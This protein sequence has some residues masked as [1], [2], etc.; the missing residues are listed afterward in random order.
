V[1]VAIETAIQ[2]GLFKEITKNDKP[3]TAIELA[4]ATGADTV[5]LSTP[6]HLAIDDLC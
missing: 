5:F 3:K 6:A 4:E 1:F 2:L